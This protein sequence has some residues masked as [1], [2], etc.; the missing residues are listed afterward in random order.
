MTI[1]RI[2]DFTGPSRKATN[3]NNADSV[4]FYKLLMTLGN[5]HSTVYSM[6]VMFGQEQLGNFHRDLST[7]FISEAN[8]VKNISIKESEESEDDSN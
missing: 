8:R 3:K 5:L 1:K 4:T 6:Y 7:K 2:G